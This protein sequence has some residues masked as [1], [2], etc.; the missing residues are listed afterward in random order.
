MLN[1]DDEHVTI[2]IIRHCLVHDAAEVRAAAAKAFGAECIGSRAIDETHSGPPEALNDSTSA[3]VETA[4][5]ALR[6]VIANALAAL[7]QVA[8]PAMP[9]KLSRIITAFV[10]SLEDD[11][12]SDVRPDVESAVQIIFA[13]ISDTDFLHQL[14]VLLLG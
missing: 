5:A 6:D 8:D 14:M 10:K 2:A 1:S 9:K 7:V 12:K 11:K 13:S 3:G 4:L